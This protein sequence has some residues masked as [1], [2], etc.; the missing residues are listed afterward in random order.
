MLDHPYIVPIIEFA[1][2]GFGE[3]FFTMP[4]VKGI[5]LDQ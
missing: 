5:P 1:E 4:L 3:A 2:T